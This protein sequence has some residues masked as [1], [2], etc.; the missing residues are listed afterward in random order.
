MSLP[1]RHRILLAALWPLPRHLLSRLG[2]RLTSVPLPRPLRPFAMKTFGRIFGVDFSEVRD[3]LRSFPSIQDFFVR[4]L[5]DGARPTDAA[6]DAFVSP[7]DGAWGQSG[8]VE[9]GALLQVKGRPY[10]VA[11]LLGDVADAA[12]FEGGTYA[13][14]YLSPK[15]YHRFHM[16]CDGRAV[17]A[18][19]L[20]GGLWP[21]NRA[22]VEGIEALFARNERI[23]GFFD[24]GGAGGRLA[25]AAV[26]ATMVGKVKLTFDDLETN[27]PGRG[28][29]EGVYDPGVELP[30][31]AEWGRFEFGSTLV[32]VASPG[33]VDLD[34]APAGTALRLGRRIG[35]LLSEPS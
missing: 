2:G 22:G 17:R 6:P 11:E 7:C 12:D 18:R 23:V 9:N 15:D 10:S 29:S 27:V 4:A 13:T 5:V 31:G 19:Y 28:R 3:P 16:P 20:P 30:K 35:T 8:R 25:I 14:L 24:V 21:V 34:I 1:F 32:L 26:G 33:L